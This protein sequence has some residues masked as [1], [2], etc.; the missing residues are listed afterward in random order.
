MACGIFAGKRS[1]LCFLT[2]KTRGK[3][4]EK[5]VHLSLRPEWILKRHINV[6]SSAYL[7]FIQRYPRPVPKSEFALSKLKKPERLKNYRSCRDYE[8]RKQR[9]CR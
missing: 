4:F 7:F 1:S 3:D 5:F 9:V 2:R 8:Q 6:V